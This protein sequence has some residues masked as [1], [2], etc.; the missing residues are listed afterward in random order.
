M[1]VFNV[2]LLASYPYT[3]V[4]GEGAK[5]KCD[6]YVIVNAESYDHAVEIAKLTIRSLEWHSRCVSK[7]DSGLREDE[8]K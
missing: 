2:T 7:L 3:N 4:S 6:M 1:K 5:G 8:D